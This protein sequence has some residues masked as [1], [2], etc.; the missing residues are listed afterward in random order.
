MDPR[1]VGPDD[2][3]ELFLSAFSWEIQWESH[4]SAAFLVA[5]RGWGGANCER[6]LNP[7]FHPNTPFFCPGLWFPVFFT[8]PSAPYFV[9]LPR[10]PMPLVCTSFSGPITL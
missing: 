8:C 6:L 5:G 7:L 2:S 10:L 4:Q 9:T 1:L 3:W